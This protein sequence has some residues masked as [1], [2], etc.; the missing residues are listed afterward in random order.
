MLHH[1]EF[2]LLLLLLNKTSNICK[3]IARKLA[4]FYFITT[5]ATEGNTL[6][7]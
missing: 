3:C 4:I 1:N 2:P 6:R 5:F 7:Y